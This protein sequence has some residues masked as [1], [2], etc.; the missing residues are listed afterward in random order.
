MGAIFPTAFAPFMSLCHVSGNSHNIS[1]FIIILFVIVACDQ[2][3]LTLLLQLAEAS[4]DSFFSTKV[5]LKPYTFFK[6]LY[7]C[8]LNRLQYGIN[9]TF[10]PW[11]IKIFMQH[12]FIA[13]VWNHT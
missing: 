7:Y 10:M 2:R 5:F 9:I 8:T 3:S 1:N 12:A 11:E 13:V 4:D 6:I